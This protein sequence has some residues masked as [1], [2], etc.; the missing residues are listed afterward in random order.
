MCTLANS[1]DQDEQKYII[2]KKLLP[3]SPTINGKSHTVH[4]NMYGKIH[5]NTKG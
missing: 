4:S 1:E 3:V 2:I 5:Q